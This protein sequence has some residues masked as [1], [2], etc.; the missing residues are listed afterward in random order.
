M[1][2]SLGVFAW[3]A[4]SAYAF[5]L[6]KTGE[7]LRNDNKGDHQRLDAVVR[8]GMSLYIMNATIGDLHIRGTELFNA[9]RSY[10]F[11]LAMPLD[12]G[13]SPAVCHGHFDYISVFIGTTVAPYATVALV[14]L[15]L[16]YYLA[17]HKRA[18]DK[19]IG[20]SGETSAI[21]FGSC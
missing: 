15:G 6:Y 13:F 8:I 17:C 12:I 11:A 5:L 4:I 2:V 19:I 10:V 7:A 18:K 3:V 20:G 1:L 16:P 9:V 14:A 21:I